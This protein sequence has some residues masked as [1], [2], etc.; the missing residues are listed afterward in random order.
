MILEEL[1]DT[2]FKDLMRILI[3]NIYYDSFGDSWFD[4]ISKDE[5]PLIFD[6]PSP[7]LTTIQH[8]VR[9]EQVLFSKLKE[10]CEIILP[11]DSLRNNVITVN[12]VDYL[13]LSKYSDIIE[14]RKTIFNLEN[15]AISQISYLKTLFKN[16]DLKDYAIVNVLKLLYDTHSDEKHNDRAFINYLLEYLITEVD[17]TFLSNSYVYPSHIN[18]VSQTEFLDLVKRT[19][20]YIHNLQSIVQYTVYLKTI[21]ANYESFIF[22]N[23]AYNDYDPLNKLSENYIKHE[24]IVKLIISSLILSLSFIVEY[25]QYQITKDKARF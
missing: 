5:T 24:N 4:T 18:P 19:T 13:Y 17:S 7:P 22:S 14:E 11:N 2:T 8:E 1:N 12:T 21:L 10:F 25:R 23:D 9:I 15:I 20:G 16:V 3:T 6:G